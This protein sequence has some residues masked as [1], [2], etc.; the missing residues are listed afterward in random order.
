MA[1]INRKMN[2]LKRMIPQEGQSRAPL[3]IFTFDRLYHHCISKI[4]KG[5]NKY[6]NNNRREKDKTYR[7]LRLEGDLLSKKVTVMRNELLRVK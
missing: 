2:F 4:N 3:N 1:K 7:R 5:A 6:D